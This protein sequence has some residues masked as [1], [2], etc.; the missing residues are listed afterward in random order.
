MKNNILLVGAGQLGSR[1]LQGLIKIAFPLNIYVVDPNI[2]ALNES[3]KRCAEISFNEKH[4]I[5][6]YNS[7]SLV[8][9]N[10][11]F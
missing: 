5:S 9:K 2:N 1:Y 8:P 11:L 4:N 10:F 3:I 6:Y 7:P